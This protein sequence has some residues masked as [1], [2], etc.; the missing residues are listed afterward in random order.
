MG[1][2]SIIDLLV[3]TLGAHRGAVEGVGDD[4][5][6]LNIPPGTQLVVSTDT[7]VEGVHFE[8]GIPA[9]DIGYKSLAVNLSDL[10]AMAAT[11]AWFFLA[12]TLPSMREE[13]VREFALGMKELARTA[14]IRLAGGDVTS[15]PLSITVT[16]CGLVDH[17]AALLRSGAR[18]GDLLGLSGATG[19]AARALLDLQAGRVPSPACLKALRRPHPRLK[20]GAA[21]AGVANSGIDVS[22]GLLA[23]LRHI[24]S[25]SGV[26]ARIDLGRLP[27]SPELAD[28]KDE[29]RWDVQLGGGDDYELCFTVDPGKWA[30]VQELARGCGADAIAIG[31]VVSGDRCTAVRPDGSEY[32]PRSPGYVHGLKT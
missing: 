17:G 12:L 1:E 9:A 7:L 21:L 30:T 32:Q 16:A 14:D 25:A 29:D 6:I 13:W 31:E 5:A 22:D 23:D 26:G 24:C 28:L 27:V 2:F 15:G 10:A 8:A 3:D 18:E 19:L 20:F 11:P 4:G